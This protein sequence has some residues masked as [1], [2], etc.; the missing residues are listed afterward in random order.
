MNLH[1]DNL[2]VNC[3]CEG[4]LAYIFN[5]LPSP[6]IRLLQLIHTK[7]TGVLIVVS[8]SCTYFVGNLIFLLTLF[9]FNY[10]ICVNP[11]E[12]PTDDSTRTRSH[13]YIVKSYLID[14]FGTSE[15]I[16][17]DLH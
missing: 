13:T 4:S 17:C 9:C 6:M 10:S 11:S 1:T 15:H 2:I 7:P 3:Q 12:E 16:K 5:Y 8:S 14:S